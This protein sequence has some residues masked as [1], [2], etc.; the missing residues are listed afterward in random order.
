MILW[1]NSFAAFGLLTM[2]FGVNP[3]TV[4]FLP[5]YAF[6]RWTIAVDV[7]NVIQI[8]LDGQT[9]PNRLHFTKTK[10]DACVLT[11]HMRV[12]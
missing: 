3:I 2:V 9:E 7:K 4:I 12:I 5:L 11:N 8:N 6:S 1:S 10:M